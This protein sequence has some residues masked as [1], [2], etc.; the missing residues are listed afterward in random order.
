MGGSVEKNE[1]TRIGS[2]R[3]LRQNTDLS[4]VE[5]KKNH[6]TFQSA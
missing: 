2:G 6:E 1:F 3:G 4:L 5:L